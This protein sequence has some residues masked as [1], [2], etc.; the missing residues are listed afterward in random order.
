M[1]AVPTSQGGSIRF[2]CCDQISSAICWISV[3]LLFFF[4]SQRLPM[5]FGPS[6]GQVLR[7]PNT[8]GVFNGG[9]GS[10]IERPS[11]WVEPHPKTS[12]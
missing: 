12:P 9:V 10:S 6:N 3:F 2:V 8:F 11:V 5:I 4:L 1:W 7:T